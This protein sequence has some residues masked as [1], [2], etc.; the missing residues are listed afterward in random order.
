MR[1]GKS[2][3]HTTYPWHAWHARNRTLGVPLDG[4]NGWDLV[5]KREARWDFIRQGL[6]R[7]NLAAGN[8]VREYAARP[9]TF[10]GFLGRSDYDNLRDV[11]RWSL[12]K[13]SVLADQSLH[14]ERWAGI[15][16]SRRLRDRGFDKE[17]EQKGNYY[18]LAWHRVSLENGAH[19]ETAVADGR[20]R[21]FRTGPDRRKLRS[22][23]DQL[24]ASITGINAPEVKFSTLRASAPPG[25]DR[26]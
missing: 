20:D 23:R 1:P 24:F 14:F 12:S 22:R 7:W 8:H 17:P 21:C 13:A 9:R 3:V 25:P 6:P 26:R 10:G 4:G 18:C 16:L 2:R 11:R 15:G 5:G 19:A